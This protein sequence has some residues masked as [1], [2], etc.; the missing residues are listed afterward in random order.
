M[1]LRWFL[2]LFFIFSAHWTLATHIVKADLR[3]DFVEEVDATS[4]RYNLTLNV[5]RDCQA[6]VLFDEEVIIGLYDGKT[7]LLLQTISITSYEIKDTLLNSCGLKSNCI[8]LASYTRQI[9]LD[10]SI[11]HYLLTYERCCRPAASNI[12]DNSGIPNQSII[13]TANIQMS[14][15]NT[16]ATL[17]YGMIELCLNDSSSW[18]MQ[19]SDLEGDSVVIEIVTPLVS[20]SANSLQAVPQPKDSFEGPGQLQFNPGYSYSDPFG[21]DGSII[22]NTDH[23]FS[24][25]CS[26]AGLYFFGVEIRE[27]RAGEL[28][29]SRPIDLYCSVEMCSNPIV[30]N[31]QLTATYAGGFDVD[32]NW[33][34]C[35]YKADYF[36]LE[37]RKVGQSF[38]VVD[39]IKA[40][41][42]AYKDQSI[43]EGNSVYIYHITSYSYSDT[44]SRGSNLASIGFGNLNSNPLN[45]LDIAVYPNPNK[46]TFTI[47][48]K[49]ISMLKVLNAK[50]QLVHYQSLEN[51]NELIIQM[52]SG[53]GIYFLEFI[54]TPGEFI[55][56]RIVIY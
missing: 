21:V 20:Q 49:R 30:K 12:T 37:R 27:Y 55:R 6:Q 16:M 40:G 39:T 28:I 42:R 51:D 26:K 18:N 35:P 11:D 32:L 5:F 10:K 33:S 54:T 9:K 3:C 36:V 13:A 47:S 48:G 45:N 43:T 23:S 31:S 53:P 24:L 44:F 17:D 38:L 7:K 34:Y 15:Q 50:G 52:H 41:N 25:F 56:E 19:V 8:Q 1:K 22:L 29:N 2:P 46:G 4:D 14:A